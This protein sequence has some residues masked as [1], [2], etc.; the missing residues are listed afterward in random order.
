M[1]LVPDNMF[2][3]CWD[4]L[5]LLMLGYILI[6]SPYRISFNN[7]SSMLNFIDSTN[8]YIF[9]LDLLINFISA[10]EDDQGKLIYHRPMI[11]KSY[12]FGWFFIDFISSIPINSIFGYFKI[13]IAAFGTLNN[14]VKVIKIA[15]ILRINKF[16]KNESV[17][18]INLIEY[19][20]I[21]YL[22]K[23]Q[24]NN[25]IRLYLKMIL[26][27]FIFLHISGCCWH[28]IAYLEW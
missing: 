24:I 23:F 26:I 11:I 20:F 8:D 14:L 27:L 18:K 12:F 16:Q 4:N 10:Y 22:N 5:I 28:Y 1:I 21:K 13:D 15:R 2:K 6:V 17:Q 9:M 7:N 25:Q 19:N 3:K